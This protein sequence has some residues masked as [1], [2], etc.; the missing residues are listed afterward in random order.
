MEITTQ[1]NGNLLMT[2]D[3]L[4]RDY[5]RDLRRRASSEI[6]AEGTSA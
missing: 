2:A 4:T 6:T 3:V 5:I 1:P